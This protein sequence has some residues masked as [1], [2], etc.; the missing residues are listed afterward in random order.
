MWE[1]L[2][3][4]RCAQMYPHR[5]EPTEPASTESSILCNTGL[6]GEGERH[7]GGDKPKAEDWPRSGKG[8]EKNLKGEKGPM[9]L[10][11]TGFTWRQL[12]LKSDPPSGW[13]LFYVTQ[14]SWNVG[15][16]ADS[17]ISIRKSFLGVFESDC[18]VC[19][20]T[21]RCAH[22]HPFLLVFSTSSLT[23]SH[24]KIE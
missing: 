20:H 19:S 7:R 24:L 16:W 23:V 21:A 17:G 2:T 18:V 4:I 1:A 6:N 11:G 10:L 5:E 22:L 14:P 13:I 8:T 15:Q 12:R 9:E 3:G